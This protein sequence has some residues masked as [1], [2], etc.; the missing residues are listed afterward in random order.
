MIKHGE[1][2]SLCPELDHSIQPLVLI[3]EARITPGKLLTSMQRVG[4][5]AVA[6]CVEQAS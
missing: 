1:G 3:Q 2:G 4:V 6:K 5:R